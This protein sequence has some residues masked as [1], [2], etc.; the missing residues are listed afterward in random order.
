MSSRSR[1]DKV[2]YWEGALQLLLNKLLLKI[3]DYGSRT[4]WGPGTTISGLL[5]QKHDL[6]TL[7]QD[8]PTTFSL[9]ACLWQ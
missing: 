2:Y 8:W 4:T 9:V 1:P 6:P 5:A 3:I 7:K